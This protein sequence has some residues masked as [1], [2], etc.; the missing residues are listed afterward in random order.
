MS[1]GRLPKAFHHP[2][3]GYVDAWVMYKWLL[4][5]VNGPQ[6]LPLLKVVIVTTFVNTAYTNY[7]SVFQMVEL[8]DQIPGLLWCVCKVKE[9]HVLFGNHAFLHQQLKIEKTSPKR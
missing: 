6:T 8:F 5:E 3:K 1:A 4:Y 9:L 2:S 7:V